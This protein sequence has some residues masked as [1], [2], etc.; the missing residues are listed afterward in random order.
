MKTVRL[1]NND[2]TYLSSVEIK[3]TDETMPGIIQLGA[4][5][6]V[7]NKSDKYTEETMCFCTAGSSFVEKV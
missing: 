4:K 6:F 7:R 1:Y 5:M 2:G 3:A